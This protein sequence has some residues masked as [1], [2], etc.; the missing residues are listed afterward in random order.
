MKQLSVKG[1]KTMG[2]FWAKYHAPYL[3]VDEETD[4]LGM[5]LLLGIGT[6]LSLFCEDTIRN[7]VPAGSVVARPRK[8]F[9]DMSKY[10][11]E[12]L[13]WDGY[14]SKLGIEPDDIF[15]YYF[16]WCERLGIVY[17]Y[18]THPGNF[19]INADFLHGYKDALKVLPD[20]YKSV[21]DVKRHGGI[22]TL[23]I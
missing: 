4:P 17:E 21:T 18:P 11:F 9:E 20:F 2:W 16:V 5:E 23:Y 1:H 3:G 12:A 22:S 10:V 13:N 15:K 7:P 6:M 14:T 8:A 19:C